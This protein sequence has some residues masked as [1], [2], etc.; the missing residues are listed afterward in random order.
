M[1]FN[2]LQPSQGNEM[3]KPILKV[4]LDQLAIDRLA[5]AEALH[6]A[7][8]DD[9]AVYL[10]GYVLEYSFKSHIC[11][12]NNWK[13]YTPLAESRGFSIHNLEEL[14]KLTGRED[15]I[16]TNCQRDWLFVKNWDPTDRYKITARSPEDCQSFIDSTKKI[17][18]ELQ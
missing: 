1:L 9:G 17:R 4:D 13:Q 18:T 8:R 16:N 10:C 7:G 3:A 15:Q 5:D 12:H 2:N 6:S 11:K 14:I